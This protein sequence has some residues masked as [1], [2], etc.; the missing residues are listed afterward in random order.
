MVLDEYREDA[1]LENP[2]NPLVTQLSAVVHFSQS[3]ADFLNGKAA[4]RR[5]CDQ[6]F[7]SY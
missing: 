4:I 5:Y 2:S 7:C 6:V 1:T 3:S